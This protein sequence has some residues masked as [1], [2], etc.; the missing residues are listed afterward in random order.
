MSTAPNKEMR[1][2]CH[3]ARDEYFLCLEANDSDVYKCLDLRKVVEEKC[4]KQWVSGY[5]IKNICTMY[6]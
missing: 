3:N 4:P 2:I 1:R 6:T 5:H